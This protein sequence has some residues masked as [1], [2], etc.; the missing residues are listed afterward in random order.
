LKDLHNL[1]SKQV[2]QAKTAT[3]ITEKHQMVLLFFYFFGVLWAQIEGVRA[4][5]QI[6]Y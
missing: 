4:F 5:S 1:V 2:D 3:I 6:G